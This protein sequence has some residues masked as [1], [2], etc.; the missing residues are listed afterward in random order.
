LWL[1][2]GWHIFIRKG[3][4]IRYPVYIKNINDFVVVSLHVTVYTECLPL[5]F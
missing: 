2:P 1:H 4:G 5:H 3:F